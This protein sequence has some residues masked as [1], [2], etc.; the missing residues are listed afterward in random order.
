M[1]IALK[2]MVNYNLQKS[3]VELALDVHFLK[4]V[5]MRLLMKKFVE[6]WNMF[7]LNMFGQIRKSA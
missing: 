3:I 7:S 5:N 6:V 2:S 1:I 4:H